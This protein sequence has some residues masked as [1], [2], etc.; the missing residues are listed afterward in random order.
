M[1]ARRV[2][3]V[4]GALYILRQPLKMLLLDAGMQRCTGVE[5]EQGQVT[6]LHDETACCYRCQG[7]LLLAASMLHSQATASSSSLQIAMCFPACCT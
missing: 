7:A 1:Q 5:T 3:A 6:I 2:A 4:N